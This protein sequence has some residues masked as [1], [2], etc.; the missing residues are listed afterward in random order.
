MGVGVRV[1]VGLR[2][3]EVVIIR[4]ELVIILV[5]VGGVIVVGVVVGGVGGVVFWSVVGLCIAG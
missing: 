4:H 5:R 2:L 1:G 3:R